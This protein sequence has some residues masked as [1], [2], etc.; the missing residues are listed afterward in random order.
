MTFLPHVLRFFSIS[1]VT[2]HI[3][4]GAPI[5]DLKDRKQAADATRTEVLRL[6]SL[7]EAKEPASKMGA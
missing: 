2:A 6:G 5:T 1:S 3:S 4:F 7:E